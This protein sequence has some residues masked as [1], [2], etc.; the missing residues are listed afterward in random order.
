MIDAMPGGDD[1]APDCGGHEWVLVGLHLSLARGGEQEQV[2]AR[3]GALRYVL[4][5][6]RND[7]RRQKL[8]PTRRLRGE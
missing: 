1:A 3:C 5:E 8:P 7:P 2:C 6:A 4:D